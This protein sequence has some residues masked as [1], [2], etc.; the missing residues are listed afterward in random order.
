MAEAIVRFAELNKVLAARFFVT[1]DDAYPELV[2]SEIRDWL[3]RIYQ[4]VNV[5]ML[6]ESPLPDKYRKLLSFEELQDM[7]LSTETRSVQSVE[8]GMLEEE[9][10]PF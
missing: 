7:Q 4:M 2:P 9:D 8:E 3:M 6:G 1:K 10:V 5:G